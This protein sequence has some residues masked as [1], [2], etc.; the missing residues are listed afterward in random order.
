MCRA[1]ARSK[2]RGM[3]EAASLQ[4]P[5]GKFMRPEGLSAQEGV[6]AIDT[7]EHLP[8]RLAAALEGLNEP[9][10]DTPY[11]PGG[12]TVRQ[13]VHHIADSHLNAYSRMRLAITSARPLAGVEDWPTI[14]AYDQNAWAALPEAKTLPPAISLRLLE[15]LHQRWVGTLRELPDSAWTQG[16]NHPESGPQRLDQVL[17]L[18][19]WHSRHHLAHIVNCRQRLGW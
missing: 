7:L 1:D 12:W 5:I 8:S 11:R 10:L 19:A 4:Y 3:S 13:L 17:A 6:T 14:Y 18:Y 2:I 16:Y 9:Q 15:A